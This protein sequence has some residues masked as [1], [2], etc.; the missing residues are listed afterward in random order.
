MLIFLLHNHL[1]FTFVRC[2]CCLYLPVPC[3]RCSY[4]TWRDQYKMLAV[5]C[6]HAYCDVNVYICTFVHN[7]SV[8]VSLQLYTKSLMTRI[9][10]TE[11]GCSALSAV[12][13]FAAHCYVSTSVSLQRNVTPHPEA[14]ALTTVAAVKLKTYLTNLFGSHI[15]HLIT[16]SSHPEELLWNSFQSLIEMN[17]TIT[18]SPSPLTIISP[19]PRSFCFLALSF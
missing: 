9:L 8:F 2:F 6:Y 12:Q 1:P 11:W 18:Q 15:S 14:V 3:V 7:Q 5:D 17:W 10:S 16:R 13:H 19:P 4:I